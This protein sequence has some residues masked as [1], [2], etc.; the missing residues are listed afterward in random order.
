MTTP[1]CMVPFTRCFVTPDGKFRNCCNT[2]PTIT[3]NDSFH[4]WWFNNQN[5]ADFKNTLLSNSFPKECKSCELSEITSGESFRT[6]I[7]D[8]HKTYSRYPKDWCIMFGNT[9]NLSCWTCSENFSSQIEAQKRSL[10]LLSAD[11][12]SPNK[13]FAERWPMIKQAV[14]ESFKHTDIVCL[15][16]LGGEPMYNTLLLDFLTELVNLDLAK[17]TRL[18]IT[19]NGTVINYSVHNLI[20]KDKWNYVSVIISLDSVGKKVEWLRYGSKWN[21]I[22]KNAAKHKSNVNYLEFACTVSILNVLD[23]PDLY[24]FCTAINTKITFNILSEPYYMSLTSWDGKK[25]NVDY[26]QYN[27]REL[28]EYLKLIGKSPVAGSK[29]KLLNY[30]NTM[31]QVRQPLESFNTELHD[32]LTS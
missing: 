14:L 1:F 2:R 8:Q 5:F 6:A 28:T 25:P 31:S 27:K 21:N 26:E 12:V 3:Y 18:E 13:Q 16:L 23:L 10:G 9:C 17:R 11:F 7:N 30:I 15:N 19:T 4:S 20:A 29:D 24:D 22:V 32:F